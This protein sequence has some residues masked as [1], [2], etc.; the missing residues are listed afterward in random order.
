[1]SS[2]SD[3]NIVNNSNTRL[4]LIKLNVNT[5]GNILYTNGSG[6][7]QKLPIGT[8]G[9]QLSSESS[10][11]EKIKWISNPTGVAQNSTIICLGAVRLGY[12]SFVGN[13]GLS[14]SAFDPHTIDD[15]PPLDYVEGFYIFYP[16]VVKRFSVW[17]L[18]NNTWPSTNVD[19]TFEIGKLTDIN[20][21]DPNGEPF[22]NGTPTGSVFIP[23]AGTGNSI[24]VLPSDPILG[25]RGA[26]STNSLVNIE[27][28]SYLTVRCNNISTGDPGTHWFTVT[29]WVQRLYF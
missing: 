19:L 27:E 21:G 12:N 4:N 20:G 5:A 26:K 22:V 23:Y 10:V 25:N 7:V 13:N 29:M 24:T 1:M 18:K 2:T 8:N 6:I 11:S 28:S 15:S 14:Y 17:P 3:V 9:Q 16:A